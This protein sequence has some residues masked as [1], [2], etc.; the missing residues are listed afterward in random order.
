MEDVNV[1]SVMI[2][3]VKGV[4]YLRKTAMFISKKSSLKHAELIGKIDRN[5]EYSLA[6]IAGL[7]HV[8]IRTVQ[9]WHDPGVRDHRNN[10]NYRLEIQGDGCSVHGMGLLRFIDCVHLYKGLSD[11]KYHVLL[12]SSCTIWI[13]LFFSLALLEQG[14]PLIIALLLIGI[15]VIITIMADHEIKLGN[16][17]RINLFSWDSQ[18][19]WERESVSVAIRS[20]AKR[21]WKFVMLV[22]G[23]VLLIAIFRDKLFNFR[24]LRI[25]K[26]PIVYAL[27][28]L[29]GWNAVLDFF[30]EQKMISP[31][32]MELVK[33]IYENRYGRLILLGAGLILLIWGI[34]G[35]LQ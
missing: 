15:T 33:P 3:S 5:K 12:G 16:L 20:G 21:K 28:V 18:V 1:Q 32:S 9:K 29:F 23:T 17:A 7:F 4:W 14:F 2:K 10:E 31:R 25:N 35:L 30:F 11:R 13:L 8:D 27:F 6:D 19:D 24:R 26:D 34:M 22:I